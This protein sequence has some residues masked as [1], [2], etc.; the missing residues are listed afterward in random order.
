MRVFADCCVNGIKRFS[1]EYYRGS[2]D[3]CEK[4]AEAIRARIRGDISV[5]ENRPG[6][7]RIFWEDPRLTVSLVLIDAALGYHML[8]EFSS[9]MLKTSAM[10]SVHTSRASLEGNPINLGEPCPEARHRD[11]G[12][13]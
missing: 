12:R 9:S 4:A 11:L 2:W 1:P 13:V 5:L 3:R 8:A 7:I 10:P 6:E